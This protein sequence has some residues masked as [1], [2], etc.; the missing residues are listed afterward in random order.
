LGAAAG[1]LA[2]EAGAA[3]A[4]T[5]AGA[6]AGL[7]GGARFLAAPAVPGALA[8]VVAEGGRGLDLPPFRGHFPA[9][10]NKTVT[11]LLFISIQDRGGLIECL[12]SCS[13]SPLVVG[14]SLQPDIKP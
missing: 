3:G 5:P 2:G 9:A 13:I 12:R 14:I 8:V 4:A 1:S 6:A 7:P 10:K 11:D